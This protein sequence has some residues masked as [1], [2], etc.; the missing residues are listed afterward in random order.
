M[1][2]RIL[3]LE[4]QRVLVDVSL[5]YVL[6]MKLTTF[7]LDSKWYAHS[8]GIFYKNSVLILDLVSKWMV[9]YI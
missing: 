8:D 9:V 3:Y 7:F 1:R 6:I 4:A 5:R 2:G